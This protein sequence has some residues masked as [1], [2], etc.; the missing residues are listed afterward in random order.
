MT[1]TTAG[2]RRRA[3]LVT[4]AALAVGA[5][6]LTLT[7][8]AAARPEG[9]RATVTITVNTLPIANALPMDLGI[10]KGFFEAQGI[11]IQVGLDP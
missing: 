9:G 6:L 4:V 7:S 10:S 2:L 8:T 11:Q 1:G 5:V 3:R